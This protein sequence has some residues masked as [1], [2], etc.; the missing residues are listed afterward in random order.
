MFSLELRVK[1]GP[2]HEIFKFMN[3]VQQR[4]FGVKLPFFFNFFFI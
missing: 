4:P 3:A 1:L 2:R